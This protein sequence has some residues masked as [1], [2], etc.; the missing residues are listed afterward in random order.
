MF[1]TAV[2][3]KYLLVFEI[4][5]TAFIFFIITNEKKEAVFH[6][7][8]QLFKF[9]V[10]YDIICDLLVTFNYLQ[11]NEFSI[12][13]IEF[14]GAYQLNFNYYISSTLV[15][16]ILSILFF[17]DYNIR[18]NKLYELHIQFEYG[19]LPKRKSALEAALGKNIISS[20]AAEQNK[21]EIISMN[22]SLKDLYCFEL[23]FEELLKLKIHTTIICIIVNFL[24]GI[25]IGMDFHSES[26]M[27]A[28]INSSYFSLISGIYFSI[29]L[30]PIWFMYHVVVKSAKQKYS[31]TIQGF[32]NVFDSDSLQLEIGKG[33]MNYCCFNKQSNIEYMLE[34]IRKEI[35]IKYGLIFPNI[36]VK[37]YG[38]AGPYEIS[39][40]F[41]NEWNSINLD[42]YFDK[43]DFKDVNFKN[44]IKNENNME[45][46]LFYSDFSKILD[47]Y[48][49]KKDN[50]YKELNDL[51]EKMQAD[52]KR[53]L[54]EKFIAKTIKSVELNSI[55]RVIDDILTNM[56]LLKSGE[57]L[58][59]SLE[60]EKGRQANEK[61]HS[62]KITKNFYL[63]RFVV[64][65]W[66][67]RNIINNNYDFK[68]NELDN[69]ITG[70]DWFEAKEFCKILNNKFSNKI[71]KGYKFDLP[72]EAQWEYACR[73]G[74]TK[75]FNNNTG[76]SDNVEKSD[77][78]DEICWYNSLYGD[79]TKP[80]GDKKP[81]SWG[82]YDM[83]GNVWEWCN[84]WY[85][86]YKLEEEIDPIGNN[87]GT[88]KVIRGGCVKSYA[89][90]CR[91]AKRNYEEPDAKDKY[92]GFR[93]ALVPID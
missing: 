61:Q 90:D 33:I 29:S 55:E 23:S 12:N 45:R 57:F 37:N 51:L 76:L 49:H 38:F 30:L 42:S 88:Y 35:L 60:D 6:Y 21:K 22:N 4:L 71:P 16:F 78:L 48:S 64:T 91:S 13:I 25:T 65:Y 10:G 68:L 11:R 41:K 70:V 85:S 19:E 27:T 74:T 75:A 43:I 5:M 20:E 67:Y 92:I 81:N 26:F 73:A 93:L 79:F 14:T 18:F 66:H 1:L 54:P 77:N 50:Y 46:N 62:V 44:S 36:I 56:V 89:C 83:H 28:L 86:N 24:F 69:P 3:V 80:V 34:S 8:Q 32:A 2:Y 53:E 52:K 59:G 72:T 40:K 82:L 63:N 31:P 7:F 87:E 84:D 39:L 47:F 17:I 58:M 15:L 9:F